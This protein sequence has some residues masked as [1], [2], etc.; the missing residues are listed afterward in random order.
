MSL[1][2]IDKDIP[3]SVSL[4]DHTNEHPV[5]SSFVL[6]DYCADIAAVLKCM[7]V[8]VIQSKQV[9]TDRLMVDGSVVIRVLYL[10]EGRQCI[11]VCEFGQPFTST[12]ELPPEAT[13]AHIRLT[14]KT[15]YVNCRATSPR[16]LDI[17]GAFTVKLSMT[18]PG[19]VPTIADL[20]GDGVY[21]RKQ[22]IAYTVPVGGAEKTFTINE[23]MELGEGKPPGESIIR[24]EIHPIL[25][26]FKPLVN[27][28]ILKGNLAMKTLYLVD[29]EQG[30][31]ETVEHDIP[32]SQIVDVDGLNE[33]WEV[34]A[35]LQVQ[36]NEV[37][38]SVNHSGDSS[39]LSVNVKLQADIRCYQTG[40]AEVVTDAYSTR[41]PLSIQTKPL[42]V[43]QLVGIRRDTPVFRD[44]F[45]LPTDNIREI[46][47]I[48]CDVD[49][50]PARFD[51]QTGNVEGRMM[52]CMLVRDN[53]NEIA[54]YERVDNLSLPVEDS[55]DN[56]TVTLGVNRV[57]YN[58]LPSKQVQIQ[59]ELVMR[60]QCYVMGSG[61]VVAEVFEDENA[62]FPEEKAA[63]K[64]YYANRGESL[65]E[66]AK[67]CHTSMQAIMEENNL[68]SDV[69]EENTML[70]VPMC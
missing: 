36:S 49:T 33:E 25:T 23:M 60:R 11:R 13:D 17:H 20:T 46:I 42:E 41:C 26:D 7:M 2:V 52:I 67:S 34:D 65:W 24:C 55:C 37:G 43:F 63:L 22:P 29:S 27:K 16:R 53:N 31:T 51:P 59:V 38:L 19:S 56:M 32:F 40:T 21:T 61:K 66:I 12:F 5:D 14:A 54:Y 4:M 28:A 9:T 64:I 44:T 45:D 50:A 3:V 69:L 68:Q 70:L 8:P 15:D 39:L 6:P 10:D 57:T 62:A 58:M 35:D 18:A 48:W 30:L 47:D 1:Q